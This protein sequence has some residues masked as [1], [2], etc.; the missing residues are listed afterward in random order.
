M[1]YPIY[2]IN[3]KERI[4]RKKHAQ[5]E[6]RKID[7]EPSNVIFLDLYKHKKGGIYGCYDSHMKV[8]NDFYKNH[9]DKELCIVFEDDFEATD[10]SILYLKKAISFIEKN[11][12]KVDILFLHDRFVEYNHDKKYTSNAYFTCGYGF[13]THVYIVT[14]KYIKSILDKNDNH[15]PKPNGIHFDIDI[16]MNANSILCSENIFFC[17]DPVFIQ[18]EIQSNNYNNIFDKII[19]KKYGNEFMFNIAFNICKTSKL[20]L[21]NDEKNKKM[22]LLI[23]NLYVKNKMKIF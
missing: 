5:K 6:F 7:I 21:K 12:D 18:E 22:M 4:D 1:N 3:L 20:L 11:K 8:W 19:K 23:H 14:R 2:C 15:L 9:L 16:N 10:N 17:K 13:L